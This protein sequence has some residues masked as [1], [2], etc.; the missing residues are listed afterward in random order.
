MLRADG[1]KVEGRGL[2]FLIVG[3]DGRVL[4]DYMFYPV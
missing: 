4:V 1:E 2:E 3:D